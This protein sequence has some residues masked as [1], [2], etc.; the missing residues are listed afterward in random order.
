MMNRVDIYIMSYVLGV[1]LYI[2]NSFA[3]TFFFVWKVYLYVLD[4]KMFK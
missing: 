4:L 2:N 3:D 1:H